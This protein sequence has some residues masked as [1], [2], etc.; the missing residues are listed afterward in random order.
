MNSYENLVLLEYNPKF[1]SGRALE[2][3]RLDSWTVSSYQIHILSQHLMGG[4]KTNI[5][6]ILAFTLEIIAELL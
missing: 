4:L 6:E 5:P 2:S 3:C 1:F